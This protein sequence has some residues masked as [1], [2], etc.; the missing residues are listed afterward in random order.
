MPSDRNMT[1]WETALQA[2]ERAERLHR[3]FFRPAGQLGLRPVWEPPVEIFEQ[4]K[5]IAVVVALPGV[6][7]ECI[8]IGLDA[9]TLSIRAERALH[10]AFAG[11]TV[12]CLEI[13]Y[14]R[15][16]RHIQLP[17]GRYGMQ[18]SE[19]VDGCLVLILER[20]E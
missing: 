19:S 17:P 15:F 16:E 3:Q 6:K 7:P 1:T 8:D 2:V 5:Q 11:G 14:G 9:N 20:S 13:P 18:Q 12:H 10:R 4:G